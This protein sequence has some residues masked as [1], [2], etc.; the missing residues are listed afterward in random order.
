MKTDYITVIGGGFAGVE[1]AWQIAKRGIKC[2]LYE[3]KPVKFSPAHKSR[4]LCELVCSN[5][6]RN[7][8]VASAI[9]LLKEELRRMGS[10]IMEAADASRVAAGGALAVDRDVFS[11]YVTDK[12]K[13]HPLIEVVYEEADEI[14]EGYTVIATGPLTSDA[15]ANFIKDD[16]GCGKL[17]FFDAAAPITIASLSISESSL[18]V[19]FNEEVSAS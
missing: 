14:P 17:H 2:R 7:A 10:V 11:A 5:S 18:R 19:A 13:N 9:G 15:M 6:L 3:M 12:I 1:A 8:D 4:N 16:L